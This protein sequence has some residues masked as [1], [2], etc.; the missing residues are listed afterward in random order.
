MENFNTIAKRTKVESAHF[1]RWES[2]VKNVICT[3]RQQMFSIQFYDCIC[4]IY[5]CTIKLLEDQLIDKYFSSIEI[6]L[7]I[8][9]QYF[10]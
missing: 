8:S 7:N 3:G 1:L 10:K 6:Y 5:F 4:V 9:I 2:Y